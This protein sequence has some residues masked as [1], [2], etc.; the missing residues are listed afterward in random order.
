M[1]EEK[2]RQRAKKSMNLKE[3]KEISELLGMLF[4]LGFTVCLIIAGFIYAA[5]RLEQKI[6]LNGTAIFAAVILAVAIS[7]ITAY[8]NIKKYIQND[9]RRKQNTNRN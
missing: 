9:D 1:H 8:K 2:Q 5:I 4:K 3:C 7:I 6:N